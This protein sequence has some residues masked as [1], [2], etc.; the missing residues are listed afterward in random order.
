MEGSAC[1][2]RYPPN[3][4][5]LE[6]GPLGPG[7]KDNPP[8]RRPAGMKSGKASASKTETQAHRS[9][10]RTCAVHT[11]DDPVIAADTAEMCGSD[12]KG[13]LLRFALTS[14]GSR[15]PTRVLTP[16]RRR[17]RVQLP[18]G[19][20]QEEPLSRPDTPSRMRAF[21]RLAIQFCHHEIWDG[22][23]GVVPVPD[24]NRA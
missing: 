3:V 2:T 14:Y 9:S 10:F 5:P 12:V 21:K 4:D 20:G 24:F 13:A 16:I 1:R 11:V 22:H 17:L 18:L 19:R 23:Q 15:L 6:S 8:S 7:L